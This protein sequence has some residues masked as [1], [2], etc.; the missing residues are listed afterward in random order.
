MNFKT[1]A[2]VISLSA[3]AICL[4]AAPA[5]RTTHIVARSVAAS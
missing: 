4:G 3:A 5:S 2:Q 1:V